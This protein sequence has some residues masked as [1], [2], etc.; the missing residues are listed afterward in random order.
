MAGDLNFSVQNHQDATELA[1]RLILRG[2]NVDRYPSANAWR[3]RAFS[4]AVDPPDRQAFINEVTDGLDAIVL[5]G[6]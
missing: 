4:A 3:V 6:D 5:E 2:Y 1:D